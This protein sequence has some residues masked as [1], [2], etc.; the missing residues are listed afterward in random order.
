MSRAT[1]RA[2]RRASRS[3]NRAGLCGLASSI[4][5]YPIWF[6]VLTLL[7]G[8]DGPWYA[9]LA[10]AGAVASIVAIVVGLCGLRVRDGAGG[11]VL[12]FVHDG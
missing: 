3:A 12:Y 4:A 10:T 11:P 9:N 1:N 2:V 7:L 8:L 6:S 5:L